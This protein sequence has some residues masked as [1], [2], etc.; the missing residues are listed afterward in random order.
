MRTR[1]DFDRFIDLIACVCFLR[2]YQKE[3]KDD[4]R[5][6]YIECD[7]TDY[8]IA[9]R[10]MIGNVLPATM[11]DIPKNTIELYEALRIMAGEL[12]KKNNLKVNEVTFTQREIRELT[13]LNH[14]FVK[15]NLRILL[16]Y[17][18]IF[19]TRGGE[20]R[21]RGVYRLKEDEGIKELDLSII[22]KPEEIDLKLQKL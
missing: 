19:L 11:S 16:E 13:G 1:R 21:T 4:G 20:R 6:K 2:Q 7:L 22:P 9:Y 12:A 17:E 8:E 10:I 18:Y 3:I 15:I 14:N 5:F